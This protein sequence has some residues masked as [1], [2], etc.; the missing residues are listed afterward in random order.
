MSQTHCVHWKYV[1]AVFHDVQLIICTGISSSLRIYFFHDKCSILGKCQI[2][3]PSHLIQTAFRYSLNHGWQS[4]T[5]ETY[6]FLVVHCELYLCNIIDRLYR[7]KLIWNG[8]LSQ[9]NTVIIRLNCKDRN[10]REL[11]PRRSANISNA[12]PLSYLDWRIFMILHCMMRPYT[13]EW[14][15]SMSWHMTNLLIA[16][17]HNLISSDLDSMHR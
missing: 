15:P 9:W 1:D 3:G 7:K 6:I 17:R 10:D 13:N 14:M 5:H 11:N 2:W 4:Y 12:L 16:R 8:Y